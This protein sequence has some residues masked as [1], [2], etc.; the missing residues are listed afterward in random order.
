MALT[1]AEEGY[2][3]LI[4]GDRAVIRKHVGLSPR[5]LARMSDL[6]LSQY[7]AAWHGGLVASWQDDARETVNPEILSAVRDEGIR[8]GFG[9]PIATERGPLGTLVMLSSQEGA[10]DDEDVDQ[11]LAS[12]N[13]IALMLE[14]AYLYRQAQERLAR[15]TALREID[16][17]I[18]T[19]LPLTQTI[20]TLL[21]KVVVHLPVDIVGVSLVD[22]ERKRTTLAYLHLPEGGTIE[23]EA[24]A[25]SDSLLEHLVVC[26]ETVVIYDVQADPRLQ[27]H[28]GII[29]QYGL[30]SYVGVPLVVGGKAIG[31]LHLFTTEPRV[32]SAEDMA[33]FRA[34]AGQAAISLENARLYGEVQRSYE[35]LK[36]TQEQ[37]LQSQKIEAIGSLA[38]GVAH[39]FNNQLTA[40][41]G[42]SDMILRS[43]P[44]D[45]P[46]R[47]DV[48]QI[49]QAAARSASLTRQL[50]LFSR[51][52]PMDMRPINLNLQVRELRRMLGRVIG[53][54]V[55]VVLDLA[56]DLWAVM[57]DPGNLDQVITNLVVNARDAMPEGGSVTIKTE[58][59]VVDEACCRQ[60][61]GARPGQFA[62]LTV[63]D[64]GVGMDE[65][66]MR[67]IFEPFFTT[68]RPGKGTGL[69]L[70]V[71]HGI[72]QAHEGWINVE[73]Q[74]GK[75]STFRIHLPAVVYEQAA[76]DTED[77][78]PSLERFRGQ[79][80]R[81]LVVEDE[82]VPREMIER[83]LSENG[84]QVFARGTV[85]GAMEV[86]QQEGESF[87]LV[88]SDVVLSDGNGVDLVLRLLE[89]Q[90]SLAVLLTSGYA[91][92]RANWERAQRSGLSFLQKPFT[93]AALL[94]RVH[95]GLK[96][97]PAG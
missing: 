81:I 86:F 91:D 15:L 85:A 47:R 22:W 87:D 83:I 78:L 4:E 17:A 2:V 61:P 76:T 39:D 53:E 90:P 68:K 35:E 96:K 23:G 60:H 69:G 40:I 65:E 64:T 55:P 14:H 12:A 50:L 28:R 79:G 72:V 57:A 63:S 3:V 88:L 52:Q 82:L 71:V 84:Y 9:I 93:V 70:S 10:F 27:N 7:Q 95:E 49:R 94:E 37:L 18:A 74:V 32:F 34:L 45:S 13:T 36:S 38:G 6:P 89:E 59:V 54:D 92:G 31:V 73:S 5:F 51:Q 1:K 48:L 80:E 67:R 46:L 25:L 41:Q 58:N 44:E 43:L 56:E 16:L 30:R 8:S 11:T 75:G 20:A 19:N 29:R 42:Y 62:R 97:K 24:F 77:I 26:Q 66:V 33:F 21:E